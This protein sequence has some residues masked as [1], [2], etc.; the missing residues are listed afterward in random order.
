[1]MLFTRLQH[2][3]QTV[4]EY[5][6]QLHEAQVALVAYAAI[7]QR[8]HQHTNP[9]LDVR[10]MNDVGFTWKLHV[11]CAHLKKQMLVAGHACQ[12]NDS[13]V[14]R[15]I[16]QHGSTLVK[17]AAGASD[18]LPIVESSFSYALRMCSVV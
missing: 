15:M 3:G 5:N 14:E 12:S 16:R 8:L 18:V 6:D 11:A 10:Y 1:M 17:C 4:D 13:W 2:A 9:V 7:A